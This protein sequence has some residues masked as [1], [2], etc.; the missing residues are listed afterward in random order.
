MVTDVS[1]RDEVYQ[2]T[3]N[4]PYPV[5]AF[6][7]GSLIGWG[8]SYVLPPT[9]QAEVEFFLAYNDVQ[10]CRNPDDCKN[11]QLAQMDAFAK[12]ETVLEP[13]LLKLQSNDAYWIG[14]SD[15]D[16]AEMLDVLWRNTGI[17]HLVAETTDPERSKAA[18]EV[19]SEVYLKEFQTAQEHSLKLIDLNARIRALNQ[20]QV[21]LTWK[22]MMLNTVK[23][24]L[25]EIRGTMESMNPNDPLDR[26]SWW[27]LYALA[28]Q[29]SGYNFAWLDL[30]DSI[31]GELEP[32]S[33]YLPWMD[34]L[35][36][37]V[38]QDIQNTYDQ[39]EQLYIKATSTLDQIA[40][41]TEN[42]HG[43]SRTIEVSRL[44]DVQPQV[45]VTRRSTTTAVLGGILGLLVWGWIW[46]AL[47]IWR[48]R[49]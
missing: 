41:E 42:S 46:I 3:H 23:S 12:S 49:K 16:L 28:A 36:I 27:E 2:V 10:A 1:L 24:K 14:V 33:T 5:L 31:P 7:I 34:R 6:L 19:W 17:W 39:L 32:Q 15:E 38:D 18:V 48:S 8:L 29:A 37:S 43:L 25:K 44:L 11:W 35:E 45:K 20:T 21:E 13:T 30:I 9:H 47:P 22:L 4:W 26:L 40:I